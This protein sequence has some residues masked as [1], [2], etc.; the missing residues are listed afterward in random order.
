[1]NHLDQL[2]PEHLKCCAPDFMPSNDLNQ[3]ALQHRRLQ[4]SAPVDGKSFIV[5]RNV[6]RHLAVQ[7]NLLLGERERSRACNAILSDG[8]ILSRVCLGCSFQVLLKKTA[9]SSR[10]LRSFELIVALFPTKSGLGH[11]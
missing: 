9:L 10:K 2:S 11:H 4:R 1:M 6:A 7:P 3:A 8:N 5:E